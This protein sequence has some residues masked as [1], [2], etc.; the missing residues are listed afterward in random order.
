METVEQKKI[1]EIKK[2]LDDLKSTVKRTDYGIN[3]FE[4]RSIEFIQG[5]KQRKYTAGWRR[6]KELCRTI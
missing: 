2:S 4:D 3:E 1:V 6:L 5:E